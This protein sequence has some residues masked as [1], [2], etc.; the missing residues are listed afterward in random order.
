MD[1]ESKKK[2]KVLLEPHGPTGWHWSQ[3]V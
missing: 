2:T 3:F 1:L